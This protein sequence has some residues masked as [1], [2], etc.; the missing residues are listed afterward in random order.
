MNEG[1][2]LRVWPGRP[3]PLGASFDGAGT[4]FA[5]FSEVAERVELCLVDD[6]GRETRVDLP[7]VTSL[8]WHG[9]LPDVYPGQRYGFR[10]HGPWDPATG[11][12]CNPAKLLLDPYARAIEGSIEWNP[13][14][15]P[16]NLGAEDDSP[17]LE[18]SA[19]FV[20]KAVV[21]NPFFDWGNDRPPSVPKHNTV[22]YEVHVRGFTSQHPDLPE[23]IRGTYAALAS[24]PVVAYLQQLGVTTVELLPVHEFVHDHALIERGLR[25]YWGYNSIGFFAPHHEYARGI[26]PGNQ[27]L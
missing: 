5:L 7:E 4:N 23:E 3:F 27:V 21:A 18:D 8:C 1:I 19:P 20:P 9:Y 16:Y 25:N 10:V 14:L 13:A 11:H 2:P 26:A 24:P 17:N 15:Y 6:Q 22:I 12:R